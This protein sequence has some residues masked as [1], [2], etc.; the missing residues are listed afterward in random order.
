MK[1][2]YNTDGTGKFGPENIIANTSSHSM[3]IVDLDN[4]GL[5]SLYGAD[6]GNKVTT[7]IKLWKAVE[8]GAAAQGVVTP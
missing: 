6:Y 7:P 2:F 5:K 4:N 3:K 8:L 1:L